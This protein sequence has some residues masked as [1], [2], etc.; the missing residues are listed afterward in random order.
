MGLPGLN[1]FVGEFTILLGAFGSDAIG[2]PWYAGISAAGVIMAAI[3]ILYMFQKMFLG[4]QGEIVDEVKKH[5]HG[6]RDLNWREIVTMV[7]I[8]IFIFWIGL[9]P[10][11]FFDLMAPAVNNLIAALSTAAVAMH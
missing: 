1:G 8:L 10:K 2:S 5:G 3:Y 4:P 7:P 9:Y 11:P 6:L